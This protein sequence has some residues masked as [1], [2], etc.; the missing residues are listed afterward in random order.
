MSRTKQEWSLAIFEQAEDAAFQAQ[1]F[2]PCEHIW[3][4]MDYHVWQCEICADL[5]DFSDGWE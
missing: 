5:K 3:E 2:R 4:R 1:A